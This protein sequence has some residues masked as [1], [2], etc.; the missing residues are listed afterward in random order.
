MQAGDRPEKGG[1]A[2][3]AGTA[4]RQSPAGFQLKI[5]TLDQDGGIVR[6]GQHGQ[7]LECNMIGII[8][9]AD[10]R[11]QSPGGQAFRGLDKLPSRETTDGIARDRLKL[12]DDQRQGS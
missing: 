2:R 7:I 5:Q 10:A 8:S 3:P 11:A 6:R 9:D 4:Y 12:G 1:S